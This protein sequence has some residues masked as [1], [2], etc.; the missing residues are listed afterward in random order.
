MWRTRDGRVFSPKLNIYTAPAFQR[1]RDGCGGGWGEQCLLQTVGQV[2]TW[3]HSGCEGM[4]KK[5][6]RKPKSDRTLAWSGDGHEVLPLDKGML[7]AIR[8]GE[9]EGQLAFLMVLSLIDQAHS[10]R[11]PHVQEYL[12]SSYWPWWKREKAKLLSSRE[13]VDLGRVRG[14][15]DYYQH[16]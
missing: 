9:R 3:S 7:L 12:G 8:C 5:D 1:L 4:H 2:H 14:G 11:R 13:G 10:S 15:W 16:T 6:S